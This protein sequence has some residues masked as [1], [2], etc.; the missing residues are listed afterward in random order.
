MFAK[1]GCDNIANLNILQIKYHVLVSAHGIPLIC[2]FGLSRIIDDFQASDGQTSSSESDAI[3][4]TL[5]WMSPELLLPP[6]GDSVS[7]TK[8]SDVWA[9]GMVVCVSY[10]FY[11][12]NIFMFDISAL[13]VIDKG[14]PIRQFETRSSCDHCYHGWPTSR[15]KEDI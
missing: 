2:G 4:G 1:S 5:R 10:F 7:H 13:G 15:K 14:G 12:W 3:S 9:F 6:A 11:P 8:E